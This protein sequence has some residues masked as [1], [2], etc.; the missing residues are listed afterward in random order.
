MRKSIS[1][2][3]IYSLHHSLDPV[4]AEVAAKVLKLQ[5]FKEPKRRFDW[6]FLN[7]IG[8]I[9][10]LRLEYLRTGKLSA[11]FD[12]YQST[13]LEQYSHRYESLFALPSG[14]DSREC[15]LRNY[16]GTL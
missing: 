10:L 4:I 14:N 9:N 3:P 15:R 16:S 2:N 8:V 5:C 11:P 13:R 12:L 6:D 1:A 7:D